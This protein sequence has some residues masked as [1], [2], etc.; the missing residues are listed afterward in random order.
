M[1]NAEFHL[2]QRE[3]HSEGTRWT[4]QISGRHNFQALPHDHFIG[5]FFIL[6]ANHALI[7]SE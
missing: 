4:H 2:L 5:H 1:L 7:L 6:R 3:P